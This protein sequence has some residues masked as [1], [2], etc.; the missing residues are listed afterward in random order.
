[1]K[2][3]VYR[4]PG[5]VAVERVPLP[6]LQDGDLLVRVRRASVCATD[7]K[8]AAVGHFK[9]APGSVRILGHE[10]VGEVVR[11]VPEYPE[12][13]AGTRVVVAPNIGCGSCR[14]CV[15]GL[16]NLCSRYEALGITLDG[17]L[18]EYV[19]VPALFVRRG[20]VVPV[21]DGV[22]DDEAALIEPMSTV[23]AAHEAVH[24]A[25]GDRVAVV[26]AGPM[27]LMHVV[28]ARAAGASTVVALEPLPARRELARRLG[29]DG[30]F[31]P[32]EA[33]T[34]VE[35]HTGGEGFDVVVVS[36]PVVEA[37]EQALRLAAVQGRVHLFA[38]LPR[39]AEPPRLDTNAIHYRQLLVTGTTGASAWQFRRTVQLVS[40]GRLA[41]RP[42]IS[43]VVGLDEVPGVLASAR[44]PEELKSVVR[45][46]PG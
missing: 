29:A 4:G 28:F 21:D 19:R 6:A 12:L 14:A 9:I 11:P 27:G 30:A 26:G 7:L 37:Q 2:A 31:A 36:V 32:E 15:R 23:L 34:A 20:N 13:A 25:P 35:R 8:I 43:Q 42:L 3:A 18:A 46:A 38:G 5:R 40:G 39:G 24:T 1:M 17:A 44:R 41:L 45:I 10:F 22:D 33:P 16:D